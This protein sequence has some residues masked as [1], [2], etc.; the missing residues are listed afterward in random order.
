MIVRSVSGRM[1]VHH[2]LLMFRTI[3]LKVKRRIEMIDFITD[4][5]INP[6]VGSLVI[7]FNSRRVDIESLENQVEAI[8][9]P[10]LTADQIR[11]E[12]INRKFN[13]ATKIGMISTLAASLTYA[14]LGKKKLHVNYGLAFVAFAGLHLLKYSRTLLR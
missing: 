3:S 5:R 8:I 2:N 10:A 6:P 12:A 1:R 14:A 13:Q 11:K 4:V 7:Q 9:E